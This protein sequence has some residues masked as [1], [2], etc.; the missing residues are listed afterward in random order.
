MKLEILSFSGK[1][2]KSRNVV[3]VNCMSKIWEITV[4]DNHESLITALSPCVINVVYIEEDNTKKEVNFAVWS[5]VL[6]FSHNSMKILIDLL[7]SVD[8]LDVDSVE[9]ARQEALKTMDKYKNSQDKV[10]MEKYVEAQDVLLKSLAQLKLWKI[11]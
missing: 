6:E 1:L 4:L 11:R 3:S 2:F 5:G 7:V 8:D 9:K 10:D